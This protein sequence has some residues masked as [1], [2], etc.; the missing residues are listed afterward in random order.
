[1]R[2]RNDRGLAVLGLPWAAITCLALIWLPVRPAG[3]QEPAPAAPDRLRDRGEGVSTSMFGTYVRRGELLI[4]PFFESYHDANAEYTPSELG[5]S[6]EEDFRG[7]YRASEFLVF[8]GYGITHDLAVEFEAAVISAQLDTSPLDSSALPSRIEESG[9]GDIEGQVRWRWRRETERRPEFFSYGEV[10]IPHHRDKVLI[11]TAGWEVAVGTGLTRGFDWGT[12][13]ARAAL[14]IDSASSSP[15]DSGEYA[16]EYLRRLSPRW[17]IYAG[18]EGAQ[19][20]LALIGEVQWHLSRRAFV[21]FGSGF[22]LTSKTTD[23]APEVGLM[24]SFDRDR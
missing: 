19:D 16:I 21:K 24:L 8:L 15:F 14:E 1:M 17:R 23:V 3:A 12:L 6:S 4:Y 18:I 13:T 11:G 20:E 2:G 5:A 9:V 10:V 22:G 7:R